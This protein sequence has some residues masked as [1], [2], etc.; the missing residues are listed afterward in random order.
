MEVEPSVIEG[1]VLYLVEKFSE[2]V[3]Y[4]LLTSFL[5]DQVD[6]VLLIVLSVRLLNV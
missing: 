4:L 1:I 2:L 6:K 3:A 5:I